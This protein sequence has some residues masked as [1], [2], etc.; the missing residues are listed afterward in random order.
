MQ[1]YLKYLIAPLLAEPDRLQIVS[2]GN[3][4]TLK[5]AD[6]DVGRV[7]G[8]HGMIIHSIRTLLKTFCANHQLPPVTL[9]LETPA[10][11]AA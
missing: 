1:D 2:H 6:P 3:Y 11:P 7:I 4:L 8:K 5:V 10:K 9:M